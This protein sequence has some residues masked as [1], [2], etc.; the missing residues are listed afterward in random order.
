MNMRIRE[1]NEAINNAN[2]SAHIHLDKIL[3][4]YK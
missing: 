2:M 4:G 1:T 3:N